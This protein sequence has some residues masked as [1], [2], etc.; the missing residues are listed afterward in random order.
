MAKL[1]TASFAPGQLVRHARFGY[2]GLIFDVDACYS[3]SAEW[4]ESM[5]KS[6]PAKNRPWYHVLV[7]GEVHTTY[8]AEENLQLCTEET[9]F[10]HPL[11]GHLFHGGTCDNGIFEARYS[12]N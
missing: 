3:Q 8:V 11:F 1:K 10:E 9:P 6:E 7:D 12:I 5:A 4:Y 2:R